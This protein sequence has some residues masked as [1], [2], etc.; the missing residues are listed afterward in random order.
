TAGLEMTFRLEA[1]QFPLLT[2]GE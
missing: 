2:V 1:Q